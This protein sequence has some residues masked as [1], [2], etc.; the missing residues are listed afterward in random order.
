MGPL[1]P[2][3]EWLQQDDNQKWSGLSMASFLAKINHLKTGFVQF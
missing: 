2:V 3:F 1:C